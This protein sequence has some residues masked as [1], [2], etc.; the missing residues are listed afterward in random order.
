MNPPPCNTCKFWA[1]RYRMMS[2]SAPTLVNTNESAAPYW[3]GTC[4]RRAPAAGGF[5]VDRA[6][7]PLTFS[8][9]G[10]WEHSPERKT[11]DA[12]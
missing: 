7:W 10:C 6:A 9:D 11:P 4:A 5:T 8:D 12:G 2:I 1:P 3:M